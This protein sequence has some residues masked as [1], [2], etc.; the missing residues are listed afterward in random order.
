MT[1][2]RRPTENPMTTQPQAHRTQ[3]P[4]GILTHGFTLIEILIV[5]VI[6]GILAAI[7]I[8]QFS[9][10]SMEA[11]SNVLKDELRYMRSQIELYKAQH[12][13]IFPSFASGTGTPS[14][15][16]FVQQ[17]TGFTNERGATS[18]EKIGSFE[19]GPYLSRIPR[20]TINSLD[21]VKLDMGNGS[22]AVDGSTGWI[23]QPA[24]GKLVA[25]LTSRAPD[26]TLYSTY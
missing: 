17:M 14:A 12:F 4:R 5:V 10:A 11:R 2:L 20:N 16:T 18:S 9:S 3:R 24:T 6:L 7:V 22:I 25:N 21:T 13:D 8:P 23:Y 15:E 26:G 19:Y 1:R